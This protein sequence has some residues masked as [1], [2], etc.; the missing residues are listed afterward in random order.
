MTLVALSSRVS[1]L[2][3]FNQ[4]RQ[5]L[6]C[7]SLDPWSQ[8]TSLIPELLGLSYFPPYNLPRVGRGIGGR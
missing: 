2:L 6:L 1:L 8:G 5:S 7:C 3:S 4:G